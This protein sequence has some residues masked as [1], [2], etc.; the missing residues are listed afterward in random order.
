MTRVGVYWLTISISILG[1]GCATQKKITKVENAPSELQCADEHHLRGAPPPAGNEQ[2]CRD[3]EGINQGPW[4][5]WHKNG[6]IA[7]TGN[8]RNGLF[9]GGLK[10][11]DISGQ[12]MQELKLMNGKLHGPFKLHWPHGP[13][14]LEGEHYANV[15]KGPFIYYNTTGMERKRIASPVLAPNQNNTVEEEGDI[16]LGQV[17]ASVHA[18]NLAIEQ[19][20]ETFLRQDR[21]IRGTAELVFWIDKDGY[22]DKIRYENNQINSVPLL[23]CV[24]NAVARS[25][26]PKS[27]KAPV[28]IAIPLRFSPS[29]NFEE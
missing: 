13:L 20:Y 24:E 17:K 11:F 25:R 14:C 8:F 3:K 1:I 5:L 18:A 21:N 29:A 10:I 9:Q 7:A 22:A 6:K 15:K 19:C 16:N 12:L 28:T 2:W 26:F 23:L 4:K 27:R